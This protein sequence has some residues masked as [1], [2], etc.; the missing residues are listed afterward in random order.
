MGTFGTGDGS[1]LW[2]DR[3]ISNNN[4]NRQVDVVGWEHPEQVVGHHCGKIDTLA[5]TSTT[6]RWML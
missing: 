1:S 6:G 4:N 3:H 5:T 2:E